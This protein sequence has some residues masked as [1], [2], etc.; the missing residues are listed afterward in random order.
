MQ[1]PIATPAAAGIPRK[2][3]DIEDHLSA[4]DA[5]PLPEGRESSL[6]SLFSSPPQATQ[7]RYLDSL[8]RGQTIEL[9][10]ARRFNKLATRHLA[11]HFS[12]TWF[13]C[14]KYLDN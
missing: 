1:P 5:V 2:V 8:T 9:F 13:I 6:P 10:L 14:N 12:R 3:N 11:Q 7:E 4:G